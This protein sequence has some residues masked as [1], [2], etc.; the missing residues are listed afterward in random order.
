MTNYLALDGTEID[1][2]SDL[3]QLKIEHVLQRD[4]DVW[5]VVPHN[6]FL[7]IDRE[8]L[9]ERVSLLATFP[10]F[11][12]GVLMQNMRREDVAQRYVGMLIGGGTDAGFHENSRTLVEGKANAK[13]RFLFNWNPLF[14]AGC[15]VWIAQWTHF[16]VVNG[17]DW[18]QHRFGEL[19]ASG[20]YSFVSSPHFDFGPQ[21]A[22]RQEFVTS[23]L[24][25]SESVDLERLS[26]L[27]DEVFAQNSQC[28]AAAEAHHLQAAAGATSIDYEAPRLTKYERHTHDANGV[29]K[30]EVSFALLHYEKAIVEFDSLKKSHS[31]GRFDR[32]FFHGV[33]CGIAVAACLEAIANKL[34]F[35]Q[36]GA[37]PG[38]RDGRTP[39]EKVNDAASAL[40]A[41]SGGLHMP[42]LSGQPMF[43]S[44]DAL[45]EL[46]NS[47]IHAKELQTDID[48]ASLTSAVLK[49][50]DET[51]CRNYLLQLRLAVEH[52]FSQ[53]PTLT[54]PI[55]TKSNVTWMGDL[56]VP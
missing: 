21:T 11:S 9:K 55:V 7:A 6:P 40:V 3:D 16:I 1:I 43:D 39:L 44:L 34:V 24:S 42:L 52:V 35:R 2:Q 23:F 18:Y 46:R 15:L 37:H 20:S 33:Y 4:R 54:P 27:L 36:T 51:A 22:L 5:H 53:M 31:E 10:V 29:P 41:Q 13:A 32:A 19:D 8:L 56:E 38:R 26:N 50:V 45:R 25:C 14:H 47:F 12:K 49:S 30:V 17:A 28:L 48:Q